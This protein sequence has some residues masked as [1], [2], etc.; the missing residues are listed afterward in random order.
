MLLPALLVILVALRPQIF[1]RKYIRKA[2]QRRCVRD[3]IGII[4]NLNHKRKKSAE[5]SRDKARRFVFAVFVFAVYVRRIVSLFICRGVLIIFIRVFAR[6]RIKMRAK[7]SSAKGV[8]R[9]NV[10]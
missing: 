4:A 9:Q 2:R 5:P 3:L 7:N 8:A 1:F 10:L 6:A